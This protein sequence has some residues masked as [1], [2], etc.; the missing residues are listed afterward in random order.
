MNEDFKKIINN[1]FKYDYRERGKV[2]WNGFFLSDHTKS[3]HK[4]ED[5]LNYNERKL[6][7]MNLSEMKMVLMDAYLNYES[8]IVQLNIENIDHQLMHNIQGL[9]HGF[10]EDGVYID[11]Q[12]ILLTD[13][14]AVKN[15]ESRK[16]NN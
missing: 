3:L 2:K 15:N 10:S 9:V 16:I 13:M 12:H 6:T 5:E 4:N 14:R 1:F 11:Q 8:V 7:K